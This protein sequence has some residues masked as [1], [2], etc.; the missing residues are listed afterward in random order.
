MSKHNLSFERT[1][2]DIPL[3]LPPK[4]MSTSK[5]MSALHNCLDEKIGTFRS[6]FPK[7]TT[8]VV[9]LASLALWNSILYSMNMDQSKSAT[10]SSVK[11]SRHNT[12]FCNSSLL[13]V[14][15]PNKEL[16]AAY[17]IVGLLLLFSCFFLDTELLGK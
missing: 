13:L 3:H 2:K 16:M 12:L 10:S 4:M 14:T 11:S 9:L 6:V 5:D 1:L 15:L 7:C 8:I 17:T